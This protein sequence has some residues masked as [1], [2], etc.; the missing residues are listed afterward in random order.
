[1]LSTSCLLSKILKVRMY[2]TIIL[3]FVLYG[4]EVWSLILRGKKRNYKHLKRECL[5]NTAP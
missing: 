5:E 4:P 2:K 1:M 3:P